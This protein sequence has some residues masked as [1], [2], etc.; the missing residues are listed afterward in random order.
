MISL[1]NVKEK[2]NKHKENCRRSKYI[3][4]EVFNEIKVK[5]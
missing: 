4:T 5:A 3:I 2:E 1:S